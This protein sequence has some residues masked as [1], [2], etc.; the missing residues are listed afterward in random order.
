MTSTKSYWS[1]LKMILNNKKISYIAPLKHQNKY[2]TDF[3]EKEEIFKPFFAEHC[4]L[5]NNSCKLPFSLKR[6]K[7][8]TLNLP[9]NIF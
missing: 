7:F 4:S 2:V 6:T 1:T 5:M 8:I 9:H 3:K